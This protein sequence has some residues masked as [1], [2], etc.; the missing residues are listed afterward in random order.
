MLASHARE[1][2]EG[3]VETEFDSLC[4]QNP[5]NLLKH[6]LDTIYGFLTGIYKKLPKT[7]DPQKKKSHKDKRGVNKSSKKKNP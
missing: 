3:L 7:L 2:R 1:S 4:E 6:D 5:S